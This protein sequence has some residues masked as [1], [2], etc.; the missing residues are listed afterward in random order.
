M[1][2]LKQG[3]FPEDVRHY[4]GAKMLLTALGVS[5]VHLMTNN[6]RKIEALES[7]GI[8]VVSRISLHVGQNAHNKHY[9]NTKTK[10]M[11]HIGE[12]NSATD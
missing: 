9:L 12:G 3:Q 2:L 10:K 4:A 7:M 5:K 6:P 1:R 8:H 11:G